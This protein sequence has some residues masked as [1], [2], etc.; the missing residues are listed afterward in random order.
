MKLQFQVVKKKSACFRRLESLIMYSG[1][2]IIADAGLKNRHILDIQRISERNVTVHQNTA[3]VLEGKSLISVWR[4][5]TIIKKTIESLKQ[6]K[7]VAVPTS[8]KKYAKI[9]KDK[10]E[11]EIPGINIGIYTAEET[12]EIEDDPVSLWYEHKHQCIIYTGTIQ[13]GNS[14]TEMVD[15]VHGFFMTNTVDYEDIMQMLLRCRNIG[16]GRIYVC[17]ETKGYRKKI[18]PND[19]RPNTES[20]REYILD[21]DIMARGYLDSEEFKLPIDLLETNHNGELDPKGK[22]LN[23]YCGYIKDL[24]LQQRGTNFLLML[25]LRDQGMHFGDYLGRVEYDNIASELEKEFMKK[26]REANISDRAQITRVKDLNDEQAKILV[27][28]DKTSIEVMELKKYRLKKEYGVE[29]TEQLIKKTQGMH[30]KH[31]NLVKFASVSGIEDETKRQQ[32]MGEIGNNMIKI[33]DEIHDDIIG[34]LNETNKFI[35]VKGCYHALNFLKLL[36]VGNFIDRLQPELGNVLIFNEEIKLSLDRYVRQYK[37]DM[38]HMLKL[39]RDELETED[40]DVL[41]ITSELIY[42]VFGIKVITVKNSKDN[43]NELPQ[44][45]QIKS[46]WIKR[47]E[48]I[49]PKGI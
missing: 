14:Y 42:N 39:D 21:E 38:R 45:L 11:K 49:I 40:I 26:G 25:A 28:K 20:I 16:T 24:V 44:T 12:S 10:I 46:I 33:K 43:S 15:E 47:E 6:G 32:V 27:N 37:E 29:V 2:V 13:A 7:R 36:G 48:L 17:L 22:Y 41:A 19:V 30:T 9:L 5:G 35:R 4:K 23:L 1:K 34:R 8:S 3:R 31:N 18:I